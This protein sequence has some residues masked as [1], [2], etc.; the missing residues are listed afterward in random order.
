LMAPS[1]DFQ[2]TTDP[3]VREFITVGGT[4]PLPAGQSSTAMIR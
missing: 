3:A 4:V 1:A 2:R